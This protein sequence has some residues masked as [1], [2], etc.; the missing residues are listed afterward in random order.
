MKD[1]RGWKV[2]P[3][4]FWETL[5]SWITQSVAQSNRF[6]LHTVFGA[7]LE[8]SLK[9]SWSIGVLAEGKF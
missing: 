9:T 2:G 1:F 7:S 8:S 3:F 5:S 4:F 6:S